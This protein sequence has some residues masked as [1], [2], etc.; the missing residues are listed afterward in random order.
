MIYFLQCLHP[1]SD[2][3]LG[4]TNTSSAQPSSHQGCILNRMQEMEMSCLF[5]PSEAFL[6]E[7]SFRNSNHYKLFIFHYLT[8]TSSLAKAGDVA[9]PKS[10]EYEFKYMTQIT[11][12]Y[13]DSQISIYTISRFP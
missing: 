4:R 9:R 1:I 8:T 13:H 3:L 10:K 12:H 11:L 6:T 7:C 2:V 5:L